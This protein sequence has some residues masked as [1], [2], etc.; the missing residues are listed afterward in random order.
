MTWIPQ[1][2]YD[3]ESDAQGWTFSTGCGRSTTVGLDGSASIFVTQTS[4]AD[5]YATGPALPSPLTGRFRVSYLHRPASAVGRNGFLYLRESGS[6]RFGVL[7]I[8]GSIIAVDGVSPLAAYLA[9]K[10]YEVIIEGSVAT[11]LVSSVS[12]RNI[13]DGGSATVYTN[14]GAGFSLAATASLTEIAVQAYSPSGSA[15]SY[16]D[17]IAVSVGEGLDS[18]RRYEPVDYPLVTVTPV[19][20]SERPLKLEGHPQYSVARGIGYEAASIPVAYDDLLSPDLQ[21]AQVRIHS[22]GWR[23]IVIKKPVPGEP[24]IVMGKGAWVGSLKST[25]AL[26]SDNRLHAWR[27]WRDEA[28]G[29][30][31]ITPAVT[32][33]SSAWW[34]GLTKGEQPYQPDAWRDATSRG[35]GISDPATTA[36]GLW[37]GLTNGT[38]ASGAAGVQFY[39][40]ENG[41]NR[42][43][44]TWSKA[45][46][47]NFGLVVYRGTAEGVVSATPYAYNTGT[48]GSIDVSLPAGTTWAAVCLA[49]SPEWTPNAPGLGILISALAVNGS[50]VW[51]RRAGI[52]YYDERGISN[53]SFQWSKP[54]TTSYGLTV[55]RGDSEGV[56]DGTP[57]AL[58][59][60]TGA[61]VDLAL[62]PGTTWVAIALATN[63]FRTP[64]LS[65]Q[66]IAVYNI[67]IR[68]RDLPAVNS[69][70]V[71]NDIIDT[72]IDSPYGLSPVQVYPFIQ[73]SPW[74]LS[75]LMFDSTTMNEKFA[76][77][78]E[79]APIEY[80]WY[81]GRHW[82]SEAFP[83]DAFPH[84]WDRSRDPA[85]LIALSSCEEPPRIE[86]AA[87]DEMTSGVIVRYQ[88]V[89]GT[90]KSL[91]VPD[92]DP[93]H[94]LVALGIV[95]YGEITIETTDDLEA[96][97]IA[98][99]YN[100][101]H[102]RWR[103]RGS[104]TVR[105]L[106]TITGGVADRHK[107]RPGEFMRLTGTDMGAVDVRIERITYEGRLITLEFDGGE[108]RLDRMLA[109]LR[110][111]R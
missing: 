109:H 71:T 68:G 108:Y 3:F 37:L 32:P 30:D 2:T 100:S 14:G 47:T 50:P 25:A 93:T 97:A 48:G 40:P 33:S 28:A 64:N 7:F 57:L 86:M 81:E 54:A 21:G 73:H 5:R 70:T 53:V 88:R 13:T 63:A 85:Y 19:G 107:V 43:Q 18:T 72:D 11:S 76:T 56:I 31:A 16:F 82:D 38:A 15:V 80:G 44:A 96:A 67:D 51:Y 36:S 12:I 8:D 106:V 105:S 110:A 58:Q 17:A 66:G 42:I 78:M 104:V 10:V 74:V 24:L 83:P 91:T 6:S 52:D 4:L 29:S 84:V 39:D 26:Y 75:P 92:T 62:P 99:A 94:P 103:V 9:G 90:D 46:N 111:R 60:G 87:L 27:E 34:L 41:V 35:S 20:G 49:V 45:A 79:R 95:R 98:A 59:T 61:Y 89:D 77:L 101:A 23:G 1:V 102:G 65:A 55:L 22:S 69:M